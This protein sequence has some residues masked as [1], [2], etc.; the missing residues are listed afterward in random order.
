MEESIRC[1]S[2]D[3]QGL[4]EKNDARR[5][6]GLGSWER[7]DPLHRL[8][9]ALG[10]S[11]N[12]LSDLSKVTVAQSGYILLNVYHNFAMATYNCT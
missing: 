6:S 1:F 2:A 11:R 3:R 12:S 5:N 4:M 10:R 7:S 8:Q 9:V